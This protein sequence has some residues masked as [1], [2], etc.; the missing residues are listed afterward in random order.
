[1]ASGFSQLGNDWSPDSAAVVPPPHEDDLSGPIGGCRSCSAPLAADQRYCIVCG[2][3]RG[4][5]SDAMRS[6]IAPAAGIASAD[7]VS[8]EVVSTGTFTMPSPRSAAVA[9]SAV[10]AFGVVVGS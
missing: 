2:T 1:M 6:L 3:R 4:P 9:V 8:D 5:V 7:A 10:L